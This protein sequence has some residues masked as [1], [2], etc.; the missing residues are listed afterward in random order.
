MK[1]FDKGELKKENFTLDE[2]TEAYEFECPDFK[3]IISSDIYGEDTINYAMKITNKYIKEKDLI[4]NKMLDIQ[5]REFYKSNFNY[6]DNDIKEKIGKPQIKI[7]FKKD[8]NHPQWNFEYAG[9]I[10]FCENKLDEHIISI[11]FKDE[12]ILKNTIYLD[13]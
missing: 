12:L 8:K 2:K 5:L 11:E 7:D 1:L 10:E 3:L 4:L 6:T 13:G 9:I